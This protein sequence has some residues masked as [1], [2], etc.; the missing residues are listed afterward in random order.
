MSGPT[1]RLRTRLLAAMALIAVGV[2]V[3]AGL[4]TLGLARH[5]AVRSA[6]QELEGR[7]PAIA[8]ELE[9][10]ERTILRRRTEVG[11][12]P[13]PRLR[14]LLNTTLRVTGSSVVTVTRTGEVEPGLVALR[15]NPSAANAA[16]PNTLQL[17]AGL[18]G[19]DLDTARLQAGREQIGRHG[20]IAFLARPLPA[21]AA[22]TPVLVLTKR[23]DPNP[24]GR[25]G[26]F[27]LV[28]A[29]AALAVAVVVSFFLARRLTRPLAAMGNTA[30]RIAGGDLAAR[31]DLGDHPDDELADL[32]RTL[33]GMASQLEH[34]RGVE[35]AFILSVSHDLRTPLTS[36]RGYAE[37][38][39]DGTLGSGADPARAAE[40]IQSE[41]RRLERLVADLLDLA[42]LDARQF[43]LT[44]R[45]VDAAD[46]IR[47][48]VE[49]FRPAASD[50]GV[51]LHVQAPDRLPAD[52]DPDR[53]GQIVANLVENA[54]KYARTTIAVDVRAY[55]GSQVD[56][57]IADDGPGI[58][59]DDLPRV[60]E[61]LY[62]SRTVPG[63]SVG[64]GLGLAI[65]RE[66]AHAMGGD[67]WVEP[68]ATGTGAVFV[69][70]LPVL[71][72]SPV[73]A[74]SGA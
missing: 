67:V 7:A 42:R 61:R 36:I 17:P 47:T 54:L 66:L 65:V 70:R 25:A 74:P 35:R 14:A 46:V 64:T 60:F 10:L 33:N 16:A 52:A 43:S 26:G 39:S 50:L 23:I 32:A 28:T 22:G 57:R 31:V 38:I 8:T 6:Q 51:T 20:G 9:T 45:S 56:V 27:F 72:A 71:S 68:G 37:A 73:T 1:Q 53:L 2:L 4:G 63:R 48:A 58:A 41:A 18:S 59:P 34:A 49:A 13:V 11:A 30:R 21:T 29:A 24:A 40:V 3:F 62:T 19:G 12:V 55:A 69:V 44:P 5:E 15:D